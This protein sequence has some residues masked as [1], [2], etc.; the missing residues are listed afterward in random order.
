MSLIATR[1]E[2]AR[3]IGLGTAAP[4][5]LTGSRAA[6][7]GSGSHIYEFQKDFFQ[8]PASWTWGYT[9]GVAVDG[10]ERILVHHT[11][12]QPMAVFDPKGKLIKSWDRTS[13]AAPTA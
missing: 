1:R 5:I 11:G 2:F 12:R 3:L 13:K 9:H 8:V 10:L 6:V 7:L 4:L